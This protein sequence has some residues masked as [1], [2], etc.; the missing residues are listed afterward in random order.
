[1]MVMKTPLLVISY[2]NKKGAEDAFQVSCIYSGVVPSVIHTHHGDM[3][4]P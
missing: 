3:K 4:M 2:Q 1:M